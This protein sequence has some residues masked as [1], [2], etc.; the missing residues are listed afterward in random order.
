MFLVFYLFTEF[1]HF[2]KFL[3]EKNFVQRFLILW[4]ACRFLTKSFWRIFFFVLILKQH[5]NCF[6]TTSDSWWCYFSVVE[7]I[8][9]SMK[10]CFF[11]HGQGNGHSIWAFYVEYLFHYTKINPLKLIE[12]DAQTNFVQDLCHELRSRVIMK[13]FSQA[14]M[15]RIVSF[16]YV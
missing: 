8:D 7:I 6:M 15:K 14:Y 12:T 1:T 2:Y 3:T 13:Q 5:E 9:S 4:W 10:E 11:I 16:T